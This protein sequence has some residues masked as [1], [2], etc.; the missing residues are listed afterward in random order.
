MGT[1]C[2]GVGGGIRFPDGLFSWFCPRDAAAAGSG[3]DR[4]KDRDW[5]GARLDGTMP[6]LRSG[7]RKGRG[8]PHGELNDKAEGVKQAG[9]RGGRRRGGKSN[10]A[11]GRL[12][13]GATRGRGS[14]AGLGVQG[15]VAAA[16]E[17]CGPGGSAE[18]QSREEGFLEEARMAD[19]N[20]GARSEDKGPGAE[21]E[22]ST[23]PIPERVRLPPPLFVLR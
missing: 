12:R 22:G 3:S 6:V 4:E 1:E 7:V 14:A 16:L 20:S 5:R 15:E 21:D 18:V 10:G 17:K 11:G 13:S 9:G 19:N 2:F 8:Q 23:A